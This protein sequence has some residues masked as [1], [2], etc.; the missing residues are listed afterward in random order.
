MEIVRAVM[1]KK[2]LVEIAIDVGECPRLHFSDNSTEEIRLTD[3]SVPELV[4]ILQ[5]VPISTTS[6]LLSPPLSSPVLLFLKVIPLFFCPGFTVCVGSMLGAY[7]EK[8]R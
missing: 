7:F 8:Y 5:N 2:M 3:L 1:D 4:E 6:F